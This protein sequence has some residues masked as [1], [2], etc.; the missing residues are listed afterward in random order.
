[1]LAAPTLRH[2]A[3]VAEIFALIA[4]QSE[5]RV[6][7]DLLLLIAP[8]SLILGAVGVALLHQAGRAKLAVGAAWAL[9]GA[10]FLPP[11]VGFA[12]FFG[13]L[14]SPRHF[15]ESLAVLS[16]RRPRQWSRVVIPLTAAA[17]GLA[18]ATAW[19]LPAPDLQTQLL[20]ASF[21][22]LSL[23]VVPHMAVPMILQGLRRARPHAL[24]LPS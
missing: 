18:G 8:V 7:A 21:V 22:T 5:A 13:L 19:L 20:R 4:G 14:H 16:W 24:P 17:A 2:H 1:V 12:L 9:I 23:L 10:V 11:A 3:E 6:V 15:G